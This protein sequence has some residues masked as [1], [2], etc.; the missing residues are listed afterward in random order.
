MVD[1]CVK[2]GTRIRY[3]IGGKN[4]CPNCGIIP[5]NQEEETENGDK[6]YIN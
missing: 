5:E 6:S 3:L 4:L 1:N 2:C